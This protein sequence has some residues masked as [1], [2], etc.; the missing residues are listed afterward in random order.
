MKKQLIAITL[1]LCL[2]SLMVVET[3]RAQTSVVPGV[4][5]GDVYIYSTY[6]YWTSSNAYASIPTDLVSAN[7]TKGIEVGIEEVNYTDVTTFTATYYTNANPAATRGDTNLET[8]AVTDGG[9]PAIIG[10]NL[11][12]GETIHPLG[13]D[14]ITINQTVTM[15]G[16][17]TN[18]IYLTYYNQSIGV[19]SSDDRY[20][21]QQTGMLVKEVQSAV[22]DGSVDGVTETDQIT[23]VLESSPWNQQPVQLPE[24]PPIFT[25]PVLLGATLIAVIVVKK[26]WLNL[27][28][29]AAKFKP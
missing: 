27:T 23:M 16:R 29:K 13:V 17:P 21:D 14:G 5:S 15:N 24:F 28:E 2:A 9:F 22:D 19:T 7:Q 4:T 1:L 18:E 25:L 20:F 6:S 3:V 26:K 8:G 10:A 11:T 12:V